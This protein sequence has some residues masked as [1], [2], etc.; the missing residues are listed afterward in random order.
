MRANV[1][2]TFLLHENMDPAQDQH[3]SSRQSHTDNPSIIID[4]EGNGSTSTSTHSE[5]TAARKSPFLGFAKRSRQELLLLRALV[6]HNPFTAL[7]GTKSE[8]WDRV[9]E[10]LKLSDRDNAE[11]GQPLMFDG[12]TVK[13]CQKKWDAIS[14]EQKDLVANVLNATGT[15]PI[16]D[17]RERAIDAIYTSQIEAQKNKTSSREAN[18]QKRQRQ[19]ENKALGE[20]LRSAS[21]DKAC[22]RHRSSA[23]ED[24]GDTS[25]TSTIEG[26][27]PRVI[28]RKG[29]RIETKHQLRKRKLDDLVAIREELIQ[30]DAKRHQEMKEL[31]QSQRELGQAQHTLLVNMMENIQNT[32]TQQTM[33]LGKVAELLQKLVDK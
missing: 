6:A 23:T 2:D 25:S 11:R 16:N 28:N 33:V 20:A 8:T 13:T 24:D 5:R 14:A 30:Q 29:M 19:E 22:Y 10:Y 3:P 17:E 7:H 27:A 12:V 31:S 26:S 9:L 18:Q 4:D 15:V 1:N 32:G 21:L